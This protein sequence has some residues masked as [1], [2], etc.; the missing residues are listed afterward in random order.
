MNGKL[1]LDKLRNCLSHLIHEK[2]KRRLLNC[3]LFEKC[4]HSVQTWLVS[5]STEDISSKYNTLYKSQ[6]KQ[7]LWDEKYLF[8]SFWLS[9]HRYPWSRLLNTAVKGRPSCGYMIFFN[10]WVEV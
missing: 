5:V 1:G 10:S 3:F 8:L 2:P 4:S 9:E 6:S 7:H